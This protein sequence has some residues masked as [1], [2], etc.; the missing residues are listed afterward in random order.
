MF[1]SNWTSRFGARHVCLAC[2]TDGGIEGR[3]SGGGASSVELAE[4]C[5]S[6]HGSPRLNSCFAPR[7][8]TSTPHEPAT[9]ASHHPRVPAPPESL[10]LSGPQ[11]PASP[12]SS[13]CPPPQRIQ[14][15][16]ATARAQPPTATPQL[17]RTC[18]TIYKTHRAPARGGFLKVA[19]S[20]APLPSSS[21][22]LPAMK[23]AGLYTRNQ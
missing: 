18:S 12:L 11:C 8:S 13:L 16:L 20:A 2:E 9:P 3:E 22:R 14:S 23:M 1:V 7:L 6:S 10:R 19:V 5:M 15:R 17:I 21:I 4:P